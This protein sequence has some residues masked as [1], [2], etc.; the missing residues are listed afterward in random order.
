V[1]LHPR[2]VDMIAHQVNCCLFSRARSRLL[3]HC[4]GDTDLTVHKSPLPATKG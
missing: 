2:I 4:V 1:P 3:R